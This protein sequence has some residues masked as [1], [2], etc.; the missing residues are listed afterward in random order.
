V[1]SVQEADYWSQ[2]DSTNHLNTCRQSV[3]W[4]D[5]M[6]DEMKIMWKEAV[7][8]YSKVLCRNTPEDTEINHENRITSK[9]SVRT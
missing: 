5:I 6:N 7:A 4:R 9:L 3:E 2:E 1:R 8:S